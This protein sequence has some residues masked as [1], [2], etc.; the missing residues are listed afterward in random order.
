MGFDDN[1]KTIE[2]HQPITGGQTDRY[3]QAGLKEW[4]WGES[5]RWKDI[6]TIP[7]IEQLCDSSPERNCSDFSNKSFIAV[8][9]L[10]FLAP[11]SR[12]KGTS[13]RQAALTISYYI[14]YISNSKVPIW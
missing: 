7:N 10:T 14:D 4:K 12:G 1:M 13:D 5:K 11:G 6:F 8:L 3:E 2:S 9:F